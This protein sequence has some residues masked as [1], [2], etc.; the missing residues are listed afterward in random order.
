MKETIRVTLIKF[1]E[2]E[3]IVSVDMG[4]CGTSPGLLASFKFRALGV[5]EPC[6]TLAWGRYLG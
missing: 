1:T 2:G 4:M 5:L 6:R 3:G